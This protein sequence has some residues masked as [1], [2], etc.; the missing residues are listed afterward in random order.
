[1]GTHITSSKVR[2]DNTTMGAGRENLIS[3]GTNFV[4]KISHLLRFIML[5]LGGLWIFK[6][7][8]LMGCA[9]DIYFLLIG[10]LTVMMEMP[11]GLRCGGYSPTVYF[12]ASMLEWFKATRLLWGRGLFYIAQGWCAFFAYTDCFDY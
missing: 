11:V 7:T 10:V 4:E 3:K 2:H 8:I 5:G 12:R 6:T 9:V 1:M